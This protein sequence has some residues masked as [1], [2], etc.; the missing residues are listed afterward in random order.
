MPPEV[1]GHCRQIHR[2]IGIC[3]YAADMHRY[4]WI[5]S[6]TIRTGCTDRIVVSHDTRELTK[7]CFFMHKS[8][9][10]NHLTWLL[11]IYTFCNSMCIHKFL[12]AYSLHCICLRIYLLGIQV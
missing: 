12:E 4:L 8:L 5:Y 9:Y 1:N 7:R 11:L 6:R 10:K 3:N 2:P